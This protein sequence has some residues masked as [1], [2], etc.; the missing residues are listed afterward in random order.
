MQQD[1]R[2]EAEGLLARPLCQLRPADALRKAEIVLDLRAGAGLAADGEALDQRRLEPFRSG[3]DGGAQACGTGPIDGNVVFRARR[4]AEPAELFGDLAHGRPLHARAVGEDADRQPRIVD[5]LQP[6]FGA[7]L[8]IVLQF[9]PLEGNVAALQVIADG[10]GLR[11][12]PLSVETYDGIHNSPD[13][14]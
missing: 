13:L 5:A 4:I 3:I 10:I 7:R 2:P 8:L 14:W 12:L 11:R 6:Q 1:L 9:N